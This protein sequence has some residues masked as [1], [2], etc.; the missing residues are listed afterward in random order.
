ME[1]SIPVQRNANVHRVYVLV[2]FKMQAFASSKTHLSQFLENCAAK[3]MRLFELQ[4]QSL[5]GQ[6]PTNFTPNITTRKSPAA[7][8]FFGARGL[9]FER[10]SYVGINSSTKSFRNSKARGHSFSAHI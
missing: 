4:N 2:L 9:G 5:P 1:R 3:F 7:H 6:N 8:C 10:S